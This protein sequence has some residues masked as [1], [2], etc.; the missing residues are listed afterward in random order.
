MLRVYLRFVVI[1]MAIFFY[2]PKLFFINSLCFQFYH[3][4]LEPTH[5]PLRDLKP[6]DVHR[7]QRQV[8]RQFKPCRAGSPGMG[9]ERWGQFF[10][11]GARRKR[12]RTRRRR[13]RTRRR[14]GRPTFSPP[15]RHPGAAGRVS[16]KKLVKWWI[17]TLEYEQAIF[18]SCPLT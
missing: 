13:W 15:L 2:H 5:P 9:R 12:R 1:I 11:E 4:S 18:I 8:W 14:G 3:Q 6:D 7:A 10:E 17:V 16:R